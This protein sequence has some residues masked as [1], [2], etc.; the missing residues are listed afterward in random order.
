MSS[1]PVSVLVR[2]NVGL[3]LK[4]KADGNPDYRGHPGCRSPTS[5]PMARY[6]GVSH[7]AR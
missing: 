3:T 2:G 5:S 6:A 4:L 7:A 1:W